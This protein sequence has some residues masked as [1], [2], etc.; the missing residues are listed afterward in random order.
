MCV[1]VYIYILMYVQCVFCAIC[2]SYQQMHNM[3]QKYFV[4]KFTSYHTR[5]NIGISRFYMQ[6][7]INCIVLSG[8]I[9]FNT[10]KGTTA[11]IKL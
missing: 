10:K 3:Y 5:H 8:I 9:D 4:T 2:Y 11:V 6:P 7:P 1:C